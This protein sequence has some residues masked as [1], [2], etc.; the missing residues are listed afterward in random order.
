M[1]LLFLAKGSRSPLIESSEALSQRMST[2]SKLFGIC[3]SLIGGLL[4]IGGNIIFVDSKVDFVDVVF[5]RS[6]T[7]VIAFSIALKFKRRNIWIWEVDNDKSIRKIRFLMLLLSSIGGMVTLAIQISVFFLPLGDAMAI[8]FSNVITTMIMAAIFLGERIRAFK[9]VC[10]IMVVAG[11]I[12]VVKPFDFFSENVEN[13]FAN[14]ETGQKS[15]DLFRREPDDD[16]PRYY[17]YVGSLFAFF[18]MIGS[19]SMKI[20]T[21]VLYRNESTS[22]PEM[23]SLYQGFGGLIVSFVLPLIYKGNQRIILP[24]D[25]TPNYSAKNFISL[26]II[27][28]LFSLATFTRFASIR[29]NGP[30]VFSFLLTSEIVLSYLAQILFFGLIPDLKS[31]IGAIFIT[32]ACIFIPFEEHFISFFPVQIQEF[33]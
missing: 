14:N 33:L 12:L 5:V 24:L 28:I 20:I 1:V 17:L 16:N 4:F 7:Q 31:V 11:I 2:R 22:A 6:I 13:T 21:T 32:I 26:F 19:S 23:I 30:I 15:S 9:I 25:E 18:S 29:Y 3:L 27:G 8:L 10:G